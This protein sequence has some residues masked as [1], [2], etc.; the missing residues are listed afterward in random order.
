M[1]KIFETRQ[2]VKGIFFFQL[3]L[4]PVNSIFC[5]YKEASFPL[6]KQNDEDPSGVNQLWESIL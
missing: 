6:V 5:L 2:K 3:D 1:R 4:I